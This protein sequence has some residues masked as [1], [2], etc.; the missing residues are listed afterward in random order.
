MFAGINDVA[1]ATQEIVLEVV[2][3]LAQAAIS[4]TSPSDN[5]K[6]SLLNVIVSLTG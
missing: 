2:W 3:H 6:V 4:V 5:D 1:Q